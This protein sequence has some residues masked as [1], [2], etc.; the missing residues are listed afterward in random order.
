MSEKDGVATYQYQDKTLFVSGSSHTQT[1][2]DPY[3]RKQL[4][5]E[6][7]SELDSAIAANKKIIVGDA[8]G[9]DRQV[10]NYLKSK[11]YSNVEVYGPGKQIRY[12]ANKNWKTN[13]E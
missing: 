11:G 2:G 13:H 4:S 8:P 3:Y 12:S 5:K 9:I 10:Q 6:I 7:K 1:K